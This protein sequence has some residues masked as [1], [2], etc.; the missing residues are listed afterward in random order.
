[1]MRS[2]ICACLFLGAALLFLPTVFQETR[3]ALALDAYIAQS[4]T[5]ARPQADA[6]CHR[7]NERFNSL[8]FA[9]ADAPDG[10]DGMPYRVTCSTRRGLHR[11]YTLVILSKPAL[12]GRDITGAT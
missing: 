2:V 7:N 10:I 4:V 12:R 3:N 8:V 11:Q 6:L 5:L 1:M 9:P